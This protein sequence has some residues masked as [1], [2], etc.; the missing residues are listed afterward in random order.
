MKVYQIEE[1]REKL[2]KLGMQDDY[3]KNVVMPKMLEIKEIERM[4]GNRKESILKTLK[5]LTAK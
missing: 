4:Y 1:H 2:E 3:F 5:E